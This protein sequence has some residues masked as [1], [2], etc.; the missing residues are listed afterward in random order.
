MGSAILRYDVAQDKKKHANVLLL[1]TKTTSYSLQNYS[2]TYEVIGA[3]DFRPLEVLD[4]LATTALF[5]CMQNSLDLHVEGRISKRWLQNSN[6][7]MESWRRWFPEKYREIEV[8]ADIIVTAATDIGRLPHDRETR[9][10]APFSGGIDATFSVLRHNPLAPL[11]GEACFPISA[12]VFVHGFDIPIGADAVAKSAKNRLQ[13]VLKKFKI[14]M[15]EVRTNLREVFPM[16]WEHFHG[17]ALA[18]VLHQFSHIASNGLIPSAQ[19]VDGV[20][21][22]WGTHPATDQYLSGNLMHI[23]HDGAGFDRLTKTSIVA[24]DDTAVKSLRVCW[25]G[26]DLD[27]NCGRCEKCLRTMMALE[28]AGVDTKKAFGRRIS[29]EDISGIEFRNARIVDQFNR[30]LVAS[31]AVAD[32]PQFSWLEALEDKLRDDLCGESRVC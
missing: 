20:L 8:T 4:G 13:P 9:S 19:S 18:G 21:S 1:A 32:K 26:P 5:W 2:V 11:L 10:V 22:P 16:D 27:R 6:L 23:V 28:I 12:A 3:P 14:P 17:A 25:E 29:V 31:S 15:I 24:R 30:I 7:F